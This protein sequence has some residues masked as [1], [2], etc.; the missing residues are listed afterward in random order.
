MDEVTYNYS[1]LEL[2]QKGNHMAKYG[3]KEIGKLSVAMEFCGLKG[4]RQVEVVLYSAEAAR[5]GKPLE[6]ISIFR[7]KSIPEMK[8][9][10]DGWINSQLQM[11]NTI[12]SRMDTVPAYKKPKPSKA[13]KSQAGVGVTPILNCKDSGRTRPFNA[14]D[15]EV[16]QNE[17]E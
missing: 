11:M 15:K 10:I 13:P 14:V 6:K 12:L 5:A 8:Y 2:S 16:F 1:I 4:A 17:K 3:A 9:S 7:G